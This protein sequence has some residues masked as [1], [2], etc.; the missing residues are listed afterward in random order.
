MQEFNSSDC[1]LLAWIDALYDSDYE[2]CYASNAYFAQKMKLKEDTISKMI[3]NFKRLGL[4]EE[5]SFDGRLRV[6]RACK[7]NWF[8]NNNI[9]ENNEQVNP[10]QTR[11]KIL[12]RVGE[13]SYPSYIDSKEENKDTHTQAA[14][15]GGGGVSSSS[16][17]DKAYTKPLIS[18]K[19]LHLDCVML[20]ADEHAKLLELYGKEILEWM[21]ETLNCY[22]GSSGKKYASH[23]FVLKKNGWVYKR[24]QEEVVNNPSL[25]KKGE[26]QRSGKLVIEADRLTQATERERF[27]TTLTEAD[28]QAY[29]A[30]SKAACDGDKPK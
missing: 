17:N 22:L 27:K 19:E 16:K 26:Y 18:K 6:I 8:K 23:Y 20:T 30:K 13:K 21:L 2:G 29:L 12:G 1:M 24:Y 3:T 4:V 11:I 25:K 5:V 15:A 14:S 28:R 9:Q 10:R 7:E